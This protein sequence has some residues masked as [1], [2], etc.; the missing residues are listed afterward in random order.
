[1]ACVVPIAGDAC[2]VLLQAT[3]LE[4]VRTMTHVVAVNARA[5]VRAC[6]FAC[7]SVRACARAHTHACL[8]TPYAC[9][10]IRKG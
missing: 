6:V 3:P 4:L 5:C 7:M 10:Y 2:L 9:A 8:H 1:M